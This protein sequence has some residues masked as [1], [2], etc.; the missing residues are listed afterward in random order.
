MLIVLLIMA[1]AEFVANPLFLWAASKIVR[2]PGVGIARAY[3][4]VGVLLVLG[5]AGFAITALVSLRWPILLVIFCCS[6][7]VNVWVVKA[8]FRTKWLRALGCL[9]LTVV[10]NV[11]FAFAIRAVA[12]EAFVIA[13]GSMS[14]TLLPGERILADKVTFRFRGP[15]RGEVVFFHPP[16]DLTTKFVMRVIGVESDNL[17]LSGDDLLVNGVP[18]GKCQVRGVHPLNNMEPMEFPAVV[19]PGKLFMLGDNRETS[20]DS[21]HWGFADARQVIGLAGVIYASVTPPQMPGRF[22]DNP[23]GAAESP[24]QTR[25]ERIGK[26]IK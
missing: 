12:V 8:I 10:A 13:G 19:P 5:L 16:H 9:A 25:W 23:P 7:A 18:A 15:R 3:A 11:A 21:R 20:L 2:I 24:N 22:M 6:I 14:P 17:E 4:A 26:A 1:V